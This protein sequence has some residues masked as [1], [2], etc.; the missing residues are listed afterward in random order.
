MEWHHEGGHKDAEAGHH[1][2]WGLPPGGSDHEEAQTRQAGASLCSG[3]R[4]AHLYRH[5]VH[6]QR[7]MQIPG[8]TRR[9]ASLIIIKEIFSGVFL[10]HNTDEAYF[11]TEAKRHF[12]GTELIVRLWFFMTLTSDVHM[13]KCKHFM[14]ALIN[15]LY[16]LKVLKLHMAPHG[17]RGMFNWKLQLCC[18]RNVFYFLR[19]LWAFRFMCVQMLARYTRVTAEAFLNVS[20]LS[21]VMSLSHR[22]SISHNPCSV[23]HI[24][25][26]L[27][28][29]D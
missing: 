8:K 22:A 6:G 25:V 21:C 20:S 3:V 19:P 26:N 10:L 7:Y 28:S 9:P 4:G 23:P 1:V 14:D 2:A 13:S 24:V 29:S 11:W 12:S 16:I 27:N 17:E 18:G 15:E 5:W